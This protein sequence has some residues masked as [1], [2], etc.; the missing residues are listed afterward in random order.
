MK[1]VVD[2]IKRVYINNFSKWRKAVVYISISL[3]NENWYHD[4]RN[5][6]E[7]KLLIEKLWDSVYLFWKE[8][9]GSPTL[10]AQIWA[11]SHLLIMKLIVQAIHNQSY[12]EFY[13][14]E[15]YSLKFVVIDVTKT[16]CLLEKYI[17]L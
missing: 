17:K 4:V 7:L 8:F 16:D 15:P 10:S 12:K 11:E 2:D 14:L 6:Y 9:S 3:E 5:V 1:S 13:Q